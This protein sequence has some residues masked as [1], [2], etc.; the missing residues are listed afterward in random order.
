MRGPMSWGMYAQ[1]LMLVG[2]RDAYERAIGGGGEV[3]ASLLNRRLP[4]GF[5]GPGGVDRVGTAPL[6][7]L[8]TDLVH[9]NPGPD[10]MGPEAGTFLLLVLCYDTVVDAAVGYHRLSCQSRPDRKP[11]GALPSVLPGFLHLIQRLLAHPTLKIKHVPSADGD[12]ALGKEARARGAKLP[13][14]TGGAN[15]VGLGL[16]PGGRPFAVESAVPLWVPLPDE[17]DYRL[18]GTARFLG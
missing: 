14:P 10:G 8:F 5:S 12:P 9:S 6:P 4:T 11:A 7:V 13:S 15:P 18:E 16:D 3:E 1:Y 17:T 2:G